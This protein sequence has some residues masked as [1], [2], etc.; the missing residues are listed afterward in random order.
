MENEKAAL[1]AV[2]LS[3]TVLRV[4]LSELGLSP[5]HFTDAF[6]AEIFKAMV[7][8]SDEG[9]TPDVLLVSQKLGVVPQKLDWLAA[10]VP[11]IA[12][13][14]EY[15][16]Q[17]LRAWRWRQVGRAGELL[18]RA[19]EQGSDALEETAMSLLAPSPTE[20]DRHYSIERLRPF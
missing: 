16:K 4:Y 2:L 11:E 17:I 7:A 18:Q 10:E 15:G 14:R 9:H 20:D 5:E 6:H 1:G 12:N 19:A 3:P 13:I 8:V